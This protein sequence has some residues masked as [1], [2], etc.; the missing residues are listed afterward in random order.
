MPR[1]PGLYTSCLFHLAQQRLQDFTESTRLEASRST[2]DTRRWRVPIRQRQ[3]RPAPRLASLLAGGYREEQDISATMSPSAPPQH[4]G[5]SSSSPQADTGGPQ[6]SNAQTAATRAPVPR[7]DQEL[8]QVSRCLTCSFSPSPP[9]STCR[10]LSIRLKL[11]RTV[12]EKSW[13]AILLPLCHRACQSSLS[14]FPSGVALTSS[15]S[16]VCIAAHVPFFSLSQSI[17]SHLFVRPW[18]VVL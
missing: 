7:T 9:R 12:I 3:K 11:S 18:L 1:P 10:A 2:F 13:C 5:G 4:G 6:D 15:R 17:P 14:P 16:G 8:A